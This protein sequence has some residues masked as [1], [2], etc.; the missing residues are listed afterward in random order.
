MWN[1]LKAAADTPL[2]R[3]IKKYC[4]DPVQL[5]AVFLIMTMMYYYHEDRT[6]V[7]T[8]LAV[9]L[10][11]LVMRFYDFVAKH[12]F[13]GPLCYIV[14]MFAGLYGV[15]MLAAF[16]QRDYAISFAVWFLTPQDVV[17]FSLIYTIAIYLLMMG[18]LTSTVYYFGKVRY[19]MSMQ[20]LI[21]LIPLS[22]YAKEERQMPALLVI[23]LLA[24]FFLLM[25]YCRQL[26]S[27]DE[28]RQI[29]SFHSGAS[30]AAYVAA[31][32]II[33]AIIPKP[34]F[35][36]DREFIDNAMSYSTWSDTL[37][38]MIS[39]FMDTTSNRNLSNNNTRT[40]FYAISPEDLRLRTQTYTYYHEDDSWNVSDY[41]RPTLDYETPMTYRPQDLMQ[42]ICDA[43]RADADFA[44]RYDLEAA[45]GL[46]LE[47]Q[48]LN[49]LAIDCVVW[50]GSELLLAPTR[51]AEVLHPEDY[52]T[53]KLK[54]SPTRGMRI[55]FRTVEM[56]YYPDAYLLRDSSRTLLS[57]LHHDD[58]QALLGDAAEV[59]M[60]QDPDAAALLLQAQAEAQDADAYLAEA[61]AGDWRPEAADALA[62]EITE[63]LTSDLDKAIAIEG[64]FTEQGY[65]YDLA[66]RKPAGENAGDFISTTH[67]GVCWE[68][69]TAMTLVCR[70]AGLPT[71]FVTGY[72]LSERYNT[73]TSFNDG[74]SWNTNY[75]IKA[76]DS[77][78]FPEVYISGY[79]WVSFEPTVGIDAEDTTTRE[80]TNVMRW[81][82]VL[83]VLFILVLAGWLLMPAIRERLFRRRINRMTAQDR[84]SAVFRRMRT[85]L[86]LA[87]STTVN[88][89]AEASA[90]FIGET[91][92]FSE[93][94][95]L[96]YSQ[97]PTEKKDDVLAAAYIRWQ[98]ARHT[99]EKEQRR[100]RRQERK[101]K[102]RSSRD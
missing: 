44:K 89:L 4:G 99:Y 29:P 8:V 10:S 68:F 60:E 50:P 95:A 52:D 71:R 94:D 34:A 19:R 26:R 7:Y 30:I 59:L 21:M 78:A 98:T 81:G 75:V 92:M 12:R 49:Y 56:E 32:S 20:F 84:A 38:N 79:G 18:F 47:E 101:S 85:T 35:Q 24:S 93:L 46:T 74:T 57:R 83:L 1:K 23:L 11:Y 9:P 17:D 43:A 42:A 41:D 45:A 62:A 61:D 54:I 2:W 69:A 28:V 33:A 72:N 5:Y 6:W 13:F 66:Y 65:I 15:G 64:Y 39:S 90:P 55:S 76:R 3:G 67:R 58:Y 31:F 40:M 14:Y 82:Y 96:L 91:E 100:K 36:A 25:I 27:S 77:H 22:L 87:D 80:N 88:E 63:G 70:S 37:M 102:A 16:G 51:T 73:A 86:R 97:Q 48:P 53:N